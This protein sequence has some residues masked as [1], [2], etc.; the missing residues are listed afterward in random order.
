MDNTGLSNPEPRHCQA[1]VVVVVVV[2]VEEE[3]R[4]NTNDHSS[5]ISTQMP[6]YFAKKKRVWGALRNFGNAKA[7]HS[8]KLKLRIVKSEGPWPG[9]ERPHPV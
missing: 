7:R 6:C 5:G 2:V 8:Q 4:H 1:A 3:I 9:H